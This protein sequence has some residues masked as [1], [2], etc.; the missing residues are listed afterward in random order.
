MTL[1]TRWLGL[2]SRVRH[3]GSPALP[4]RS[5][6]VPADADPAIYYRRNLRRFAP[7]FVEPRAQPLRQG[8]KIPNL[9]PGMNPDSIRRECCSR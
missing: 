8:L 6:R 2:P 9:H 1:N 5:R 4:A 3:R 7:Q